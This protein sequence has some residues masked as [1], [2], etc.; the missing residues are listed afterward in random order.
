MVSKY[1][2]LYLFRF[3]HI[4]DHKERGKLLLWLLAGDAGD[5]VFAKPSDE[6]EE[7]PAF[8][9][10]A[11][12]LSCGEATDQST[13]MYDLCVWA[14]ESSSADLDEWLSQGIDIMINQ[15]E[16]MCISEAKRLVKRLETIDKDKAVRGAKKKADATLQA[17]EKLSG[18][19]RAPVPLLDHGKAILEKFANLNVVSMLQARFLQVLQVPLHHLEQIFDETAIETFINGKIEAFLGRAASKLVDAA[20]DKDEGA[21]AIVDATMAAAQA[22]QDEVS[23]VVNVV[24]A[25]LS[26]TNQKHLRQLGKFCVAQKLLDDET[27]SEICGVF[28]AVVTGIQ[29]IKKVQTTYN[30]QC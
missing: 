24:D 30:K 6:F 4:D 15:C 29:K 21:Q 2:V 10:L 5:R 25:V 1:K 19:L 8:G 16:A 27:W 13:P 14:S 11:R 17:L 12:I 28:E 18:C 3:R 9:G 23:R 26:E 7:E 22:F 20:V